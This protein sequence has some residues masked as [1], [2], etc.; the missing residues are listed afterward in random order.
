M[1]HLMAITTLLLLFAG[2]VQAQDAPTLYKEGLKLKEE[3]KSAPALEKFKAAT[4]LKKDYYDALYEMGWCQNDLKDYAGALANLRKARIG[5]SD[6]PKVHFE[7][8]FAFDKLGFT[9]SAIASYTQ[10]L[11][12]KTDYSGAYKQLAYIYYTK[13]QYDEALKYFG[14]YMNTAKNEINDY[15][16]WYRKGFSENAVK[17][18]TEAKES[19]QK[20]LLYKTDYINTYLELGFAC[21]KLKQDEEAINWFNKASTM[22]PRNHIPYNGIAEVYRDNKKDMETAMTWYQKALSAKPDER[23]ACFGMGYCLNS[24]K[25]YAEAI[26]YLEKAIE[27]EPTYTAAFIE[28]GYSYYKTGKET[29]ALSQFTKALDLNPKNEN[30]RYYATLVYINQKNKTKAQQMVDELKALSSKHTAT[31]QEK[32]NKL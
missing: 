8:G 14:G 12:L 1:K 7:T 5:W 9:D 15:L 22:E 20:S 4:G 25:G 32:V 3:K 16:F 19:L 17:K 13:N 30:A 18:F 24:K 28:L 26:P 29:E 2:N 27:N 21:T 31:L 10:C 23:K 6:V 11:K